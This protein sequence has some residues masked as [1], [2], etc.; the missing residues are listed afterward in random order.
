MRRHDQLHLVGME[1]Q[2]RNG[3]LESIASVRPAIVE[4]VPALVIQKAEMNIQARA[5]EFGKGLCHERGAKPP[6]H[7]RVADDA[8]QEDAIIHGLH[9]V[10]GMG[11]V[12][13]EHARAIFR[14]DGG[15]LDSG[16]QTVSANGGKKLRKMLDI[17]DLGGF[18]IAG[19]PHLCAVVDFIA[20]DIDSRGGK[21]H[22]HP[23]ETILSIWPK[24]R[25]LP[26][27][28]P[29]TSG[30]ARTRVSISGCASHQS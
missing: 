11:Q 10:F 25:D 1:Q 20:P 2:P 17:V 26:R 7:R 23:P 30:K 4:D 16:G 19:F 24:G 8:A 14:I 21:R 9:H 15:D 5:V 22:A 12:D 27:N 6:A 18:A 28:T 13:L 29:F 3:M